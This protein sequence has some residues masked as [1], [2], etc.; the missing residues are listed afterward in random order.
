LPS[1]TGSS[2]K[3]NLLQCECRFLAQSGRT[4]MFG[5]LSAFG[6]KRT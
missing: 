2:N 5:Y 1:P 4:E 3:K 6:A